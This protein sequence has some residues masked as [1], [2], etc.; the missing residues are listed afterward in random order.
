MDRRSTPVETGFICPECRN[1]F[2]AADRLQEHYEEVHSSSGQSKTSNGTVEH[3]SLLSKLA[4]FAP[5][6]RNTESEPCDSITCDAEYSINDSSFLTDATKVGEEGK[7]CVDEYDRSE[8]LE[9][10]YAEVRRLSMENE[11]LKRHVQDAEGKCDTM[12]TCLSDMESSNKMLQSQLAMYKTEVSLLTDQIALK[13]RKVPTRDVIV[14]PDEVS[15][16]IENSSEDIRSIEWF[17]DTVSSYFSQFDSLKPLFSESPVCERPECERPVVVQTCSSTA[18]RELASSL[19]SEFEFLRAKCRMF[20]AKGGSDIPSDKESLDKLCESDPLRVV[21]ENLEKENKTLQEKLRIITA[22]VDRKDQESLE[23][24][25]R[26]NILKREVNAINEEKSRYVQQVEA[27]KKVN[28]EQ[29][30]KAKFMQME[31]R[32]MKSVNA[33]LEKSKTEQ[34]IA[35][36][37]MEEQLSKTTMERDEHKSE[38]IHLLAALDMATEKQISEKQDWENE[39]DRLTMELKEAMERIVYLESSLDSVT[40]K[41]QEQELM[42]HQRVDTMTDQLVELRKEVSKNRSVIDKLEQERS[43][44]SDRCDALIIEAEGAKR[45]MKAAVC[46]FEDLEAEYSNRVYEYDELQRKYNEVLGALQDIGLQHSH[47]QVD[48]NQFLTRRWVDDATV[49]SC[50]CGKM[51]SVTVRKHHCR[52][53]GS[54][55]CNDCSNKSA[56]VASSKRPVRVCDACFEKLS[57]Q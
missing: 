9:D 43:A 15:S 41:Y 27:L 52:N 50:R 6:I 33:E 4:A 3:R 48:V 12:K 56:M 1:S 25:S 18:V 30:E 10:L 54:I 13:A 45:E 40:E 37:K 2:L 26:L 38:I 55:F 42:L 7:S 5:A 32:S 19:I 34:T 51:F 44:A 36:G 28:E 49:T 8:T 17:Y 35:I 16:E 57:A 29:D 20:L 11:A 31:L 14:G 21:Y 46:Q 22:S 24:N 53:C 47:L 23:M 39:R